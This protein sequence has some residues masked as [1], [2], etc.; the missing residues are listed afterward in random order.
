MNEEFSQA[1]RT[2]TG[3]G[4]SR[5]AF[6]QSVVVGLAAGASLLAGCT[7]PDGGEEEPQT[8]AAWLLAGGDN[9]DAVVRFGQ[10]YLQAYPDERDR[11]ALSRHV[12]AALAA[13][14]PGGG[15]AE[16][17]SGEALATAVHDDYATGEIVMV[18]G[19]ILSRTEARAYALVALMDSA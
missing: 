9:R 11:S 19:W 2:G 16:G 8:W 12:D 15:Q 14:L 17:G 18:S 7:P 13:Q 6:L 10:A 1:V 4:I 3:C 5:R